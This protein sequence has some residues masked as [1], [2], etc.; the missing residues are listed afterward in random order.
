[1]GS[2]YTV[3]YIYQYNNGIIFIIIIIM[4]V[5]ECGARQLKNEI[6]SRS[7]YMHYII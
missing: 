2:L 4:S 5:D 7:N 6:I 1:M 3:V